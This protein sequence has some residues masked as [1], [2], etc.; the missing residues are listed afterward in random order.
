MSSS[1]VASVVVAVRY[2]SIRESLLAVAFD[3]LLSAVFELLG[4]E[5][6]VV[7]MSADSVVT[8]YSAREYM[9]TF[10]DV[11]NLY[12]CDRVTEGVVT[13]VE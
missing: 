12:H 10:P 8:W 1:S 11:E 13:V 4:F 5:D 9:L 2:C 7:W 3:S 6:R